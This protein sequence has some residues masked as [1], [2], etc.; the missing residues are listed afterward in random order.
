[1]KCSRPPACRCDPGRCATGGGG[2]RAYL[3]PS[4]GLFVRRSSCH[5]KWQSAP[6]ARATQGTTRIKPPPGVPW[7]AGGGARRHRSTSAMT[8]PAPTRVT[9]CC[10]CMA[11]RNGPRSFDK[12]AGPLGDA[13][14]RVIVPYSRCFGPTVYRSSEIFRTRQQAALGKDIIDLMDALYI[15]KAAWAWAWAADAPFR[16][17]IAIMVGDGYHISA[18]H[19]A[20]HQSRKVHFAPC[21]DRVVHVYKVRLRLT[22]A[23]G[24][25]WRL[26]D[27]FG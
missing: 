17:P 4:A 15:P 7:D 14:Y 8:R 22:H 6:C 23:E 9:R 10:C 12:V 24:R 18:G 5:S 19:A 25:S 27:T 1:M 2:G 20:P 11:G 26:S 21:S 3:E 16:L 13:G